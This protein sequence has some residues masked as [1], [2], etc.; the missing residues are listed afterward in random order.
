VERAVDRA[1]VLRVFDLRA[2]D[3]VL[4][5]AAG[6]RGAAVLRGV[7]AKYDG[8]TLTDRELEERFFELVERPPCQSRV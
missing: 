2:V 7:L 3:E 8:P 6:G 4:S 5:R 1:E